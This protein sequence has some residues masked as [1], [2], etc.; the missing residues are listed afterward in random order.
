MADDERATAEDSE[1]AVDSED[2]GETVDDRDEWE[3]L[4]ASRDW[5][6]D[7]PFD[8]GEVDLDADD[9]ERLDFGCMVLTPFEGMQMQLQVDQKTKRVQAALVMSGSSAI[10]VALFAAPAHSSMVA[11]IPAMPL[12]LQVKAQMRALC[13]IEDRKSV[14]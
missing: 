9:V 8:V 13:F 3:R 2:D 6:V 5:R 4:D 1:T 10:E 12:Y 11:E 7:G 14:V